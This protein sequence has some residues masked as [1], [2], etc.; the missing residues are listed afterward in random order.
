[1][2]R[3]GWKRAGARIL[4]NLTMAALLWSM[5]LPAHAQQAAAG[6]GPGSGFA[7]PRAAPRRP[8]TPD[9]E[10]VYRGPSIDMLATIRMRGALRV[11]V[12][13]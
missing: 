6:A 11:G 8:P 5:L 4:A 10:P 3:L 12:A 2:T 9:I 7:D 13:V 1:M